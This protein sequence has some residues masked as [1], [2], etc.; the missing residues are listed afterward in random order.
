MWTALGIICLIGGLALIY[1]VMV[2]KFPQLKLIDLSTLAKERHAQ[3]KSRIIQERFDRSMGK[4]QDKASAFGSG[5]FGKIR[6]AFERAHDR[7]RTME[8]TIE[9]QKPVPAEG[10]EERLKK[11]L[12][13]A[14]AGA[15]EGRYDEAEGLYIEILRIEPKHAE[16]YRGLADLFIERKLFDQAKETLEFLVKLN[17]EDERA[18]ERLGA[19]EALSGNY[20]S[21]EEQYLKSITLSANPATCRADLGQVYLQMDQPMK[22][23][24][25][26]RLVLQAEPYNPKYLDYFIETSILIGDAKSADEAFEVLE[27]ANPENQKLAE[28]RDRIDRLRQP[29]AE[30]A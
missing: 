24:E 4:F 20:P 2:K 18:F 29:E 12:G 1:T 11:L 14:Q 27:T 10:R 16:A 23:H 26:F 6:S 17:S 28:F 8:K 22:A 3:V 15:L 19:I 25:Q 9:N 13:E 7:L 21:A 30:I 5:M